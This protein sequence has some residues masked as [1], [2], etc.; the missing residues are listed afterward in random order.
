V[1]IIAEDDSDVDAARVLIQRISK[2]DNIGIKRSVGKGCGRIKRKCLKWAETLGAKGCKYLVLIHDR[3]RHNI[4]ELRGSLAAAISPSPIRPYLICI[5]VEEMEA[6]WL[7]DPNALKRA[8]HLDRTPKIHG[9]PQS[10]PS[11]KE[12]IGRLAKQCSQGKV[13]YLNTV[14]NPVI[15]SHVD[16]SKLQKCDSFAPFFDFVKRYMS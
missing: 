4:A 5:P 16:L 9:L 11:P 2:R 6:W 12:Y 3:D 14:H 15:A 7:A 1:G 10:I 8:L 13:L